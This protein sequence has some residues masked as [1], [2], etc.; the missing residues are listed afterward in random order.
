MNNIQVSRERFNKAISYVQRPDIGDLVSYLETETDYFTSPASVQQHGNY[1]GGLIEHSLSVLEF[2][3]N[4]YNWIIKKKP[5]YEYLKESIIICSLFHD[6]CKTNSYET[7]EKWT[8]DAE[9]KWK[10]YIGLTFKNDFPFGHGEKSVLMISQ[11][12]KLTPAEMLAIRWHMGVIDVAPTFPLLPAVSAIIGAITVVPPRGR[13]LLIVVT[14]LIAGEVPEDGVETIVP[15]IMTISA[16]AGA[17]L[18]NVTSPVDFAA[19]SLVTP[20]SATSLSKSVPTA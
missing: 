18:V 11:H 3:L 12:F 5:E 13:V 7:G 1:A 10:S 8:K 2:A 16:V 14:N 15:A 20:T 4:S 17:S 19:T 9:G 6:V